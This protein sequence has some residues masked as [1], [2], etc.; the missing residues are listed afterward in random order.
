MKSKY[1]YRI[2]NNKKHYY[3]LYKDVYG[4]QREISSTSI[5]ILDE[6]VKI[7]QQMLAYNVST[8]SINFED[9]VYHYMN[10][11]HF[12]RLKPA[13][14]ERYHVTYKTKLEGTVLG[15]IPLSK[16]TVDAIQQ[17]YND[18]FA[19]KNSSNQVRELHKIIRPCLRYAYN[20][21]DLIRNYAELLE[22][23]QDP[24]EK[25]QERIRRNS[26]RPLTRDEQ[27]LFVNAIQEHE[28]GALFRTAVDTGAR[29]GELF[30]LTW[31]DIDLS[32][33]IILINKSYSYTKGASGKSSGHIGPTKCNETRRN[34]L[35][36]ILINILKI[37]KARQKSILAE[38]GV[39]QSEDSLVFSTPI[40]TYLD[41]ANVLRALKQVYLDLGINTADG[42]SNKTFHDLR[43]TYATRNFE[44]GV[45][46]LVISKLLGH[47]DINTTL[48]TYIHV[49]DSLRDATAGLTDSFY[50]DMGISARDNIINIAHNA[51]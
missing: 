43:H 18:L 33:K 50:E 8:P 22:I 10:N 6:K 27:V 15:S 45:E 51:T 20:K 14:K 9:Y 7:R 34:M 16:L 32:K 36:D 13:T 39:I 19:I 3:W 29:Q 28:Y 40:G 44:Q 35:P 17:Y 25:R 11:V 42:D 31:T 47:S 12:L 23:P 4:K 21:G 2:R 49:L 5:E 1:P 41:S 38:H 24:P 26:V 37:H 48:R 30:A 46:P